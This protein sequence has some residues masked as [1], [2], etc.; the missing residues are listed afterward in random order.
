VLP[1]EAEAVIERARRLTRDEIVRLDLAERRTGDVALTAWDL[2]RD[3]MSEPRTRALRFQARNRA[4]E[5]VAESLERLDLR[6][7]PDDEDWRVVTWI[8]SGAS[9]AARYAAC[10]LVAPE[11]LDPEIAAILMRTWTSVIAGPDDARD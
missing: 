6:P 10:A 8:G 4:W 5:A 9:R 7:T 3:R 2:L 1:P 11:L